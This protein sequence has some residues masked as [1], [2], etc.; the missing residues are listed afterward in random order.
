VDALK[1]TIPRLGPAELIIAFGRILRSLTTDKL[2]G[3][4]LWLV[5]FNYLQAALG[6]LINVWLANR[7]GP[8]NYGVL[9]YALVTGSFITLLVGFA[10]DKTLV[11]DLIQSE[12]AD[13][14]LTAS[15][16]LRL[17]IVVLVGIGCWVWLSFDPSIGSKFWPLILCLIAAALLSLMPA[18]WYDARYKMHLHAGITLGEK[19]L[20]GTSLLSVSLFFPLSAVM[21]AGAILLSS[22]TSC[23]VQWSYA[24]RS[25]SLSFRG[26]K[27]LLKWLL[28]ENWLIFFAALSNLCL[29]H[30][31]QLVLA[32]KT[33]IRNLALYAAAFQ[34]ASFVQIFQGQI[35]RLLDPMISRIT[36]PVNA[37]GEI[38]RSL[39]VFS[40]L[41]FTA[42]VVMVLPI[43]LLAPWVISFFFRPEYVGAVAPLR[44]LCIWLVI[45]GPALVNNR[46]LIGLRLKRQYFL[47]T[48][49]AGLLALGLGP[50]MI[51]H[52]GVTGVALT[53]LITH[54]FSILGQFFS[55]YRRIKLI[56]EREVMQ[57]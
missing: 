57:L 31:N 24:F 56:R 13:A 44:V 15:M 35:T 2:G 4:A 39:I 49:S 42:S 7:L 8:E 30:A 20:Y 18:A 6:F 5:I 23:L 19:G 36:M 34:I 50:F 52:W 41:S 10:S 22:I 29:T 17:T 45:F 46:F 11:R 55:V 12:D 1:N 9:S 43:I 21:A 28:R 48:F 51:D 25:Y 33:D 37:T 26:L 47:F 38:K 27:S 3:V 16:V 53:L 32:R 40:L 14:I 54:T